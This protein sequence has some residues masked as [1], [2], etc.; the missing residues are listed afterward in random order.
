MPEAS[1]AETYGDSG[2]AARFFYCAKAGPS[3]RVG[4]HPTQKPLSLVRYLVRLVTP[5]GGTALDPFA[6][7][8]T[9][10]EAALMEGCSAVVCEREAEYLELIRQR[11]ERARSRFSGHNLDLFVEASHD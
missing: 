7:S 11:V 3:E 6:G 5:P 9:T 2:S 4:N 10:A 8:G 1:G